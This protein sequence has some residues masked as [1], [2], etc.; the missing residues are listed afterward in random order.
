MAVMGT[1]QSQG[2]LAASQTL[3]T[4]DSSQVDGRSSQDQTNGIGMSWLNTQ[5]FHAPE[6]QGT[7]DSD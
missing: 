3:Q 7:Y 1:P 4:P 2:Q 5:A 6:S